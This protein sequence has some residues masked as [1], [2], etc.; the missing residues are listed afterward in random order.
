MS[1]DPNSRRGN[2]SRRRVIQGAGVAGGA[3]SA[4]LILP[5]MAWAAGAPP[6]VVVGQLVPFTGSAAEFGTFYRDAADLSLMQ[7]ND[8]AKEVFGGPIIAK[9]V[10][11]DSETLP[12]PAIAAAKQMIEA[13]NAAAIIAGWSSG[14]TV[15]VAIS[16]TIPAGVLQVAN[17]ATS[18]LISV[19]PADAHADLLFRTSPSDLL[20]GVV[21]AQLVAGQI[22][23]KYKFERVATM[24]INNPYGQ[25]LSNA[26]AADFEKRGG[27]VLAQVPHPEKVQPTYTSELQTALKDKPQLIMMITYPAQ[28]IAICKQSRDIFNFTSW[29]F[30]DANKGLGVWKGIGA[31]T[32][33]G[34]LGTSPAADPN[35]PAF[36][37]FAEV[38]KK[39]FKHETIP[40]FTADTYDAGAVIG[41][42]IAKA[43]ADGITPASKITGH[44]LAERLR[45]IANPPGEEI[46]GGSQA[47]MTK[48]LQLLKAG[49]KI[50]Y[51]GAGGPV[52]FDKNGDVKTP[53]GVWK[54][55]DT[56]IEG[57]KVVPV[58][59]IST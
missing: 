57:V 58:D 36:K 47:E 8:A 48:A 19:L 44:V 15:A 23:P 1:N 33:A 53:I 20:Q 50:N 42:A 43:V 29:Q 27:K 49:K 14:V 37:S 5:H 10:V 24:Y 51:T 40:P 13:D 55:T 56:G 11:E 46:I 26:F 16:A 3:L 52:D 41:L 17:G 18:P 28:T 25:G 35:A 4:G 9:H 31:K 22:L 38:Y 45:V 30:T 21:A 12:Q 34:K 2:V 59:K 7:I 32:L 39:T 54:F 6:A